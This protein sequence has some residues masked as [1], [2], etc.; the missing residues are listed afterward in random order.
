MAQKFLYGPEVGS[1][2]EHVR[3]EGVSERVRMGRRRRASVEEP[4]DVARP[5]AVAASV[6]EHGV[7]R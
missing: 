4:P 6:E 1:T 7:G 2:V 3:G 5:Q